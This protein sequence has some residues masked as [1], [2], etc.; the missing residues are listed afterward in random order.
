[1]PPSVAQAHLELAIPQNKGGIRL[2]LPYSYC[3]R[4]GYDDVHASP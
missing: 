1:M 2:E 3:R 4:I